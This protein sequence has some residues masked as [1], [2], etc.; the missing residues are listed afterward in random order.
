MYNINAL[1]L[2]DE[3]TEAGITFDLSVTIRIKS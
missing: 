1:K 3:L 2:N